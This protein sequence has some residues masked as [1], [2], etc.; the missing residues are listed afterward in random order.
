[1]GTSPQDHILSSR[2]DTAAV[3]WLSNGIAWVKLCCVL[4][5]THTQALMIHPSLSLHI[6]GFH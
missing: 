2:S 5:W 3:C 1:M 4:Q 6:H